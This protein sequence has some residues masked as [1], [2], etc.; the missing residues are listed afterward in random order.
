[1]VPTQGSPIVDLTTR[2]ARKRAKPSS[3][4]GWQR[5]ARGR[6]LGYRRRSADAPGRWY[7]RVRVGSSGSGSPYRLKVLGV[8]DDLPNVTAD[9]E[10]ILTFAQAVEK[11]VSYDPHALDDGEAP[12][13]LVTVRDVCASYLDW[14][15]E[16]RRSWR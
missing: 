5:I 9:G 1:M 13:E 12:Q 10:E 15:R 4:L 6:G 11:A 7:V 2:T 3:S 8:A 14:A 16:H